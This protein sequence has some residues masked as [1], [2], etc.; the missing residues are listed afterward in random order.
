MFAGLI[1]LACWTATATCS[2]ISLFLYTLAMT[3]VNAIY[4]LQLVKRQFPVRIH[5]SQQELYKKIFEP[6]RINRK[7]RTCR[8]FDLTSHR[9]FPSNY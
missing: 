4:L 6:W 5:K 9:T 7:V 1:L 2:S 3:C 8:I